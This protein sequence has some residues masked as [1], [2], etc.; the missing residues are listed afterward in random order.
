MIF[1]VIISLIAFI[2][3]YIC[4]NFDYEN[5]KFQRVK[6][7]SLEF[8]VNFILIV[9]ILNYILNV[10]GNNILFYINAICFIALFICSNI[11][12]KIRSIYPIILLFFSIPIIVLNYYGE[13]I[14]ISVLG[15]ISGFLLYFAI[16][17][18]GK[19]LYGKEV[20]GIG[21]IYILSFIG[22]ST[23]WYTVLNIGLFSFVIC[24]IYYLLKFLIL[25][26]KLNK[27]YEIPFVPFI[28]LSYLLLI[29]F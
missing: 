11:D 17:I 16:Y 25:K 22:L 23:D 7:N 18:F 2:F 15:V 10:F 20:F 26:R 12:I 13:Y 5:L 1:F 29:Y 28:T 21:D 6:I 19:L 3:G 14:K 4:T 27:E 9:I 8:L 24:L